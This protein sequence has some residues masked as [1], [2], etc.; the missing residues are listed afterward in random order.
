MATTAEQ[1]LIDAT[2]AINK[3]QEW[4]EA[5]SLRTYY[6]LNGDVAWV[7]QAEVLAGI[8]EA[9]RE[10]YMLVN[11]AGIEYWFDGSPLALVQVAPTQSI[12]DGSITLAKLANIAGISV[13]GRSTATTGVP[14]VITLAALKLLLEVPATPDLTGKVDKATGYSLVADTEIAKIHA[15]G[16]DDQDLSGLVVKVTGSSL[17]A[18]TEK[19]RLAGL[20][21]PQIIVLSAAAD[22]PGKISGA[23]VPSGWSLA[24]DGDY[25]LVI[26]HTLTGKQLSGIIMKETS[27]TVKRVC[28][29]FEEA[30]SG[31]TEEGLNITI[32]GLNTTSLVLTLILTF[33]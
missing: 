6:Y 17:I 5:L 9:E 7:D 12:A 21:E 31:I 27:G 3:L 1:L 25:N 23:T 30:Y 33:V 29:P 32:E 18:D 24:A 19:T 15:A 16:S 8:P 26:T 2:L 20:I 13:L 22:I 28:I 11:I 10:Q 4:I 14:E